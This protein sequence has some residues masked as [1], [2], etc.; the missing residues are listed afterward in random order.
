MK[1][2]TQEGAT[3]GVDPRNMLSWLTAPAVVFVGEAVLFPVGCFLALTLIESRERRFRSP[4]PQ[5]RSRPHP[6]RDPVRP[7]GC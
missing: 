4:H 3:P 5:P 1:I 2:Q 6:S 7:S